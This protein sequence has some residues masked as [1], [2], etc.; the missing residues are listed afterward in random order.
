MPMF[1]FWLGTEDTD[2]L[3]SVKVA[4]GKNNLTGNDFARELLEKELHRLH[5]AVVIF[6]E[7]G[8]EIK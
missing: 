4:Q 8:E 5:P 7:N 3:F 6:N 2:R 1:E